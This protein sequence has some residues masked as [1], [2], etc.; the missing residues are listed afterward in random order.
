[1]KRQGEPFPGA[2][3]DDEYRKVCGPRE[4]SNVS[5]R[6]DLDEIPIDGLG[7]KNRRTYETFQRLV[8]KSDELMELETQ[9]TTPQD[10]TI[11]SAP[12]VTEDLLMATEVLESGTHY[13]TALHMNIRSFHRAIYADAQHTA[14]QDQ[15]STMQTSILEL[16]KRNNELFEELLLVKKLLPDGDEIPNSNTA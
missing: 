2:R 6:I 14:L 1:M 16:K 10:G 7:E 9:R 12:R 13:S 5:R 8:R 11:S 3:A 15:I 4:P